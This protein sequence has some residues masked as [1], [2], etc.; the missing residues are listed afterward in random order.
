MQNSLNMWEGLIRATGGALNVIKGRWW[1]IDF[2]WDAQGRWKYKQKLRLDKKLTT[3]DYD[4]KI[5]EI[6]ALDPTEVFETLGVEL[7]PSGQQDNAINTLITKAKNWAE[8]I[9]V[10]YLKEKDV[11]TALNSTIMKTLE[12]PLL[13]LMLTEKDCEDIMRPILLA[14]L[15]KA[16]Y[17]RY[18]SRATIFRPKSHLGLDIHHLYHTMIGKH[19]EIFMQHGHMDTLTGKLL[20]CSLELLKIEIGKCGEL[21]AKDYAIYKDQITPC[22][23]Q[24][25]WKEIQENNIRVTE[26]SIMLQ[27]QRANDFAIMEKA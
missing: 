19:I 5:K 9:R 8:R 23:V 25:L 24:G 14:A 27:P 18:M 1:L 15:P 16:K 2:E 22:W 20:R 17:N 10:S 11:K 21:F 26:K 4:N 13:A 7:A 12:C 3:R 6:K